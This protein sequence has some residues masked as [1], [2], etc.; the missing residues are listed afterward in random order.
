MI[1]WKVKAVMRPEKNSFNITCHSLVYLMS[2]SNGVSAWK[3]CFRPTITVTAMFG[4]HYNA[5][6][7]MISEGANKLKQKS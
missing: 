6:Q 2:E 7:A 5:K 3:I 1:S 4:L